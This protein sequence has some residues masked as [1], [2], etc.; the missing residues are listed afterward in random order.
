MHILKLW[1][2]HP[3]KHFFLSYTKVINT[4]LGALSLPGIILC[5]RIRNIARAIGSLGK[6]GK[7]HPPHNSS[8]LAR[9]EP[10]PPPPLPPSWLLFNMLLRRA[11]Q[12][13][14]ESNYFWTY[15]LSLLFL[16][17][18]NQ[19]KRV[20]KQRMTSLECTGVAFIMICHRAARASGRELSKTAASIQSIPAL[21]HWSHRCFAEML[22][23]SV[24]APRDKILNVYECFLLG[25]FLLWSTSSAQ[26][27]QNAVL[28]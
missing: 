5:Q 25:I 17:P 16:S 27:I 13:A 19:L 3:C 15:L 10:S 12:G 11:D 20:L 18:K 14:R 23:F 2:Q 1:A 21:F 28:V 24:I 6:G 7:K 9:L 26:Q 8:A 4:V 22:T